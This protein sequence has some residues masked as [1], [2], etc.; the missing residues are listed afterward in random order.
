M[1]TIDIQPAGKVVTLNLRANTKAGLTTAAIQGLM[2]AIEPKTGVDRPPL[3][4]Q[5]AVTGTSF[6]VTLEALLNTTLS[7]A[8]KNRERYDDIR[9]SLITDTKIEGL[10]LDKSAAGFGRTPKKVSIMGE[11]AKGEDGL[12][13]VAIQLA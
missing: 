2:T 7:S 3:E 4:R 13:A 8:I 5:F 1:K 10:L 12:W 11:I 9:I 6:P